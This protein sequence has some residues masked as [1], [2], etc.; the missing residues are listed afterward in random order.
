MTKKE[1]ALNALAAV[2]EGIAEQLAPGIT[3]ER[4]PADEIRFGLADRAKIVLRDGSTGDPTVSLSPPNYEYDHVAQIVVSVVKNGRNVDAYFDQIVGAIAARLDPEGDPPGDVTL[5]GV[6]DNAVLGGLDTDEIDASME[7]DF[8]A[9]V[10][11]VTLTYTT[12][13]PLG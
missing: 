13:S 4:N 3:V 12:T 7:A 6:V 8:K 2:L 5:G 10:I 9:A 1:D 11:P